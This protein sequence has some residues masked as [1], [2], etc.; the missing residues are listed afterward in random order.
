MDWILIRWRLGVAVRLVLGALWG[1]SSWVHLSDPHTFLRAVQGYD[2]TPEWL[3]KAI[4]YGL[5]VLGLCIAALLI[6]GM[7]TRYAAALSGVLQVAIL[8]GVVQAW[9]RGLNNAAGFLGGAGL[10]ESPRYPLVFLFTVLMIAMSAYLVMW[11]V[12]AFSVDARAERAAVL[13][14]AS[15]RAMRSP[16]AAQR[17]QAQVERRRAQVRN[18]Q[19]FVGG[20]VAVLVALIC[21]VGMAV[22]SQRATAGVSTTAAHATVQDGVVWGSTS[23]PVTVDLYEDFKCTECQNFQQSSAAQLKDLVYAGKLQIK[24]HPIA[25]I[26]AGPDGF[27]SRASNAAL[28][29]SDISVDTFVTFHNVLFGV[30]VAGTAGDMTTPASTDSASPSPSESTTAPDASSTTSAAEQPSNANTVSPGTT[31]NDKLLDFGTKAAINDAAFTS[32]VSGN[33]HKDLVTAI[34][35]EAMRNGVTGAPHVLVDGQEL[36]FSDSDDLSTKLLASVN[37][38][39]DAAVAGGKALE[40]YTPAATASATDTPTPGAS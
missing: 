30:G 14:E 17:H 7:L 24:Y 13:P 3:S 23:A 10:T 12:T 25:Y 38:K 35:D 9:I 18:E 26:D 33:T 28:C 15:A 34:T 6:I 1:W 36:T 11:P 20:S 22:Q 2:V 27:S 39:A 37:E 16:R 19:L 29:A 32:C 4:A 31:L 21:V 5:P 40:P 8:V